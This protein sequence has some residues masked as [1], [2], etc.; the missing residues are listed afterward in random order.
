MVPLL[1]GLVIGQVVYPL[2]NDEP[3]VG[4][5][6]PVRYI[7]LKVKATA[8]VITTIT[9]PAFHIS[10]WKITSYKLT[11]R[12]MVISQV[13]ELDQAVSPGLCGI[14]GALVPGLYIDDTH[15]RA[16]DAPYIDASYHV[17]TPCIRR[18]F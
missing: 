16:F 12:G 11:V 15:G 3:R 14:V 8:T 2:S 1:L 18:S 4:S 6:L 13:I 10:V 7:T 5:Y 17:V 9:L